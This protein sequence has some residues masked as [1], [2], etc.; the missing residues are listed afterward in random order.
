MRRSH[1]QMPLLRPGWVPVP[2]SATAILLGV[3]GTAWVTQSFLALV[4]TTGLAEGRRYSDILG[5]HTNGWGP[6]GFWQL[7]TFP[8]A[9]PSFFEALLAFALLA[10]AGSAFEKLAGRW[11]LAGVYGLGSLLA[12]VFHSHVQPDIP[13]LGA[14]A[15][16]ASVLAAY[17]T[18]FSGWKVPWRVGRA[19]PLRAAALAPLFVGFGAALWWLWPNEFMPPGALCTGAV[20][21]WIYARS[22][23]FGRPLPYQR[24]FAERRNRALRLE[25]MGAEE[26]VRDEIDPILE[27][28][29][30]E[31]FHRLSR[32]ERRTLELGRQKLACQSGSKPR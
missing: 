31:G 5:L 24:L 11:H 3:L 29:S 16:A 17:S 6:A 18:V 26:F 1:R 10:L 25:N 32:A 21:G 14:S 22:L 4:P 30:R 9:S 8:L 23:G 7:F 2:P 15:G 28:I 27:K 12:G 13:L 19:R 20:C